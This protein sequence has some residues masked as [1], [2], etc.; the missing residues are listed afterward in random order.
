MKIFNITVLML[1]CST[2]TLAQGNDKNNPNVELPDFVITGKD[3][4]S[5]QKSSKIDPGIISTISGDFLK[6]IPSTEDLKIADL[7]NPVKNQI[8]LVDTQNVYNTRLS[9]GTGLYTSPAG[10]FSFAQPFS[11]GILGAVI[12]GENHGAYVDN[13]DWYKLNGEMSL[14]FYVPNNSELKGTQINFRGGYGLNAYKLYASS[15]P[16]EKRNYYSGNYSAGISNL[17]SRYFNFD[18]NANDKYTF[19]GSE[20][21]SEN[22]LRLYS[23]LKGNFQY[24]DLAININ[25]TKQFITNKTVSSESYNYIFA[26][27]YIRVDLANTFNIAGGI[28]Y[29]KAGSLNYTAPYAAIA[30]KL[31]NFISIYGEFNPSAEFLGQG[32]FLEQNKYYNP[33]LFPN[34]I[35]KKTSAF[36]AVIK[37]QYYKY[38]E[39][40][41]GIKY[42]SANNLPFF[43]T[44]ARSG[45]F[46]I[47]FSEAKDYSAFV[48]LLFHNGPYG[49]FYATLEYNYLKNSSGNVIP[50]SPKF[51]ATMSYGYN[52]GFGLYFEPKLYFASES[53]TDINNNN[54]LN[55]YIDLGAKFAYKFGNNFSLNVKFSNLVDK[56]NYKW[57]GYRDAP[58]DL[59]AGFTYKW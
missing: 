56:K 24:F 19:L 16:T 8:N 47:N 33:Q 27:P 35:V 17:I 43:V 3:V 4:I 9:I 5:L 44:S 42:F 7:S 26:Q 51:K 10:N 20:N 50:Y 14:A 30:L 28:S 13:S 6:P 52:F 1:L 37:Y 32:D 45:L 29:S 54:K 59:L 53:Y 12:N 46:D 58:L 11:T 18:L 2:L 55:S 48:N 34:A 41:A 57:E 15:N 39:I 36:D 22:L 31:N 23:Y 49:V 40:D 25:Y 21:L 38:Y